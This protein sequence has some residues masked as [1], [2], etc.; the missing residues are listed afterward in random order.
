MPSVLARAGGYE[1]V[2]EAQ[3]SFSHQ[4]TSAW[5]ITL[6]DQ[7]DHKGARGVLEV[8]CRCLN[9]SHEFED[10]GCVSLYVVQLGLGAL[11]VRD[12]VD[13]A[14]DETSCFLTLGASHVSDCASPLDPQERRNNGSSRPAHDMQRMC[15]EP[16]HTVQV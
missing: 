2:V 3:V 8:I 13:G 12:A 9:A 16:P 4:S 14:L 11:V 15:P 1:T 7:P 5:C 6:V 10:A